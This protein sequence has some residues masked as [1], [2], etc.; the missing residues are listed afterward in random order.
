MDYQKT[1]EKISLSLPD[2]GELETVGKLAAIG[3]ATYVVTKKLYDAYVGPLSHVPSPF[4]A[5]FFTIT[6][7]SL[8]KPAGT[9]YTKYLAF[10]DNY[11]DV[12]RLGP[13]LLLISDKVMIKQVLQQD[14]LQKGDIYDLFQK[15][16]VD[17]LF[18]TRDKGLHKHLRRLIS[19]AFS[20]KYLNSLEEHMHDVL[21]TLM[22]KIDGA[23]TN[24]KDGAGVVNLWKLFQHTALD[25]IGTTAFGQ[26]FDMINKESH[27]VPDSIAE[28]MRWSSWVVSHPYLTKI[29]TLGRGVKSN[30]VILD[31]MTKTIDSRI[32]SGERRNDILQILIDTKTSNDPAD[33]LSD[34]AVITETILFLIAGSETTS[35]TMGFAI[36]EL[37]RHP[38]AMKELRDE[39]DAVSFPNDRQ[40]FDH[41]QL[42]ALPY[43]NAVINETLRLNAVAAGGIER[44]ADKNLTLGGKLFVPKGT[45]I[46]SN[47]YH[48]HLNEKYW[49]NARS[50][51]PERWLAESSVKPDMDAFYPFSMGS[52]NCVG[53]NFAIMEMRLVLATLIKRFDLT[54]I[55]EEMEQAKEVRHF[56]TLTVANNKF[57]VIA[58]RR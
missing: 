48:A 56:V 6:K 1:L 47:I 20:I 22:N 25:I 39:V 44:V 38:Q 13:S 43:L 55:P 57:N 30:P 3:V 26:S 37:L 7:G 40:I 21:E 42:K 18:S 16:G 52:R 23:V 17:T 27:P 46:I 54:P 34:M 29:L 32:K 35:N 45:S 15:N 8:N 9:V 53:K 33:R 12:M 10:S 5:K 24:G 41:D 50:F 11:G 31:F 36:I 14:D 58:R 51:E 28:E 4:Y 2:R 19:P 49:P